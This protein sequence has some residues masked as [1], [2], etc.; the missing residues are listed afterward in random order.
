MTFEQLWMYLACSDFWQLMTEKKRTTDRP[1]LLPA[2]S[3]RT[4]AGSP[5]QVACSLMLNNLM[6]LVCSLL[7]WSLILNN[8]NGSSSYDG[9]SRHTIWRSLFTGARVAEVLQVFASL[10]RERRW[11]RASTTSRPLLPPS[12]DPPSLWTNI[13]RSCCSFLPPEIDQCFN[14]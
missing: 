4:R 3:Q 8:Q 12:L 1:P 13:K 6:V 10:S 2:R 11:T 7:W 9:R 5:S 14:D